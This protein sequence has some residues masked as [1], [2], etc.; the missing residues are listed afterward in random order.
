VEAQADYYP[1]D[2]FRPWS[3]ENCKTGA[4]AL[5]AVGLTSDGFSADLLR[6]FAPLWAADI[7]KDAD[8][9]LTRAVAAIDVSQSEG[10]SYADWDNH[11]ICANCGDPV[12]ATQ[13]LC[14][15]MCAREYRD[16]P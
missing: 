9:G 16:E 12:P 10:R 3:P 11:S 13:D 8:R 5:T 15:F 14:S 2:I 1:A 7:R 6:R 4:A